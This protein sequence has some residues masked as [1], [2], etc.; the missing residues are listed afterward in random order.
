M[1]ELKP[2]HRKSGF[3]LVEVMLAVAILSV[4]IVLVM[5][6][7]RTA[8]QVAKRTEELSESTWLAQ[9]KWAELI[10]RVESGETLVRE[11]GSFPENERFRWRVEST[12]PEESILR[13]T[14]TVFKL[15]RLGEEFR[16]TRLVQEIWREKGQE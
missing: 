7:F 12:E 14:L 3:T 11:E 16:Q 13:L 9:A 6:A 10:L 4:G 8:L 2:P 5:Q 1:F 15:G